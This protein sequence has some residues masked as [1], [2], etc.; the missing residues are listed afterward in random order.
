LN[1]FNA[2]YIEAPEGCTILAAAE[3]IIALQGRPKDGL[4]ENAAQWVSKNLSL[5]STHLNNIA[6]QAIEKVL[7]DASELKELW[8]ESD[9]FDTWL[10]DVT[11][12]KTLLLS[13]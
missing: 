10:K 5:D 8:E 9:D 1:E 3:I 7:S 6:I 13:S 11:Q 12:I 4:P 2:D